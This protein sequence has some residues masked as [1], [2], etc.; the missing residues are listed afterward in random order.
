MADDSGIVFEMVSHEVCDVGKPGSGEPADAAWPLRD[1][2]I[3]AVR[4]KYGATGAGV[5]IAVVDT[6]VCSAHPFF[7]GR[8]IAH[9]C[10]GESPEDDNGH[11]THCCGIVAGVAPG[12]EIHSYKVFGK[13]GQ[14]VHGNILAA[15]AE[16]K[17]EG[18]HIVN[19]SLGSGQPSHSMRMALLE[20]NARGVLICCAAG[21]EGDHERAS[22]PRFGTVS[23]PAEFNSTVAVGS[24]DRRRARSAFSSSGPKICIMAPGEGVWSCWKG[25]AQAC[26][27][28]TSMASPFMAGVLALAREICLSRGL[29]PLNLSEFL[30]AAALSCT[31]MESPGFDFFTGDGCIDPVGFVARALEIA[32]GSKAARLGR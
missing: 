28:G 3:L 2:G 15:L 31:D 22:A 6:G 23:F 27:S 12:A 21:N 11:G 24:V 32:G 17:R 7:G 20:L 13:S 29:R 9:D 10:T 16:I 5:K 14:A 19:M 1:F 8:V 4:K 25:G 30:Y 18:F 26:L